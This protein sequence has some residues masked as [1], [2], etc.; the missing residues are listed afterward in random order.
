MQIGV[1]S[2]QIL[3]SDSRSLKS[4]RSA[5]KPLL[6]YLQNH[7]N[8]SAAEMGFYESWDQSLVACVIVGNERHFLESTL[9]SLFNDIE[10]RFRNL[11][12]LD[13]KI[14]FW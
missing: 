5:I 7:F 9:Q 12:F 11:Q 3:L 2:F 1:L 8:V 10:T 6:H 4:K 14:E 13:V